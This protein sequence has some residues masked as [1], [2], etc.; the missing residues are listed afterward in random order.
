M[1]SETPPLAYVCA[2]AAPG[3]L[4]L[5][6]LPAPTAAQDGEVIPAPQALAEGLDMEAQ[7]GALRWDARTGEAVLVYVKPS[8]RRSG[9]ATALLARARAFT[10]EWGL[11]AIHLSSDRTALGQCWAQSLGEPLPP[12]TMLSRPMTPI[13]ETDGVPAR[14]LV[15]DDPDAMRP[16][17][18]ATTPTA[19]PSEI[20]RA[21][22]LV[23]GPAADVPLP[24]T[25]TR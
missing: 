15:P 18:E 16:L 6:A 11:P 1:P 19:R 17:L 25:R 23:C 21:W 2:G 14:L 20:R 24:R 9:I 7:V 12:L 8:H 22:R 10:A 5:I 3:H 13:A 4:D